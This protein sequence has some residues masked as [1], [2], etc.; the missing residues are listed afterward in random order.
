MIKKALIFYLTKFSGH[1]HA[2]VA[3]EKALRLVYGDVH[4]RNIN[5]PDYTNPIL[6]R[7][8]NKVYMEIIKKKPEIWGRMYDNIEVLKKTKKIREALHKYNMSKIKKLIKN[9]SPDAVFCTQAFPCGMISDYKRDTGSKIPLVGILTD[10]APHSYWL[11]EKVD[12]YVVPS[13]N[14]ANILREKGV[15]Q[16]KIKIYGIPVDSKFSTKHDVAAIKAKM[17][18]NPGHPTVLIMGGSQG[19]GSVEE[20]VK[21]FMGDFK[22]NYQLIV[23]TGAN[24]KLYNRLNR[25]TRKKTAGNICL[26][27]YVDN[28][29]ELMEVSDVIVTKAG[30]MTTTEALVKNL[31]MLI[32]NP[33]PG[34]EQM[35]TDYLV[36]KGAAIEI[37]KYSQIY[38]TINKLVD[39]E[40][41]LKNMKEAIKK[42]AK[43][44]SAVDIAKLVDKE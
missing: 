29:D 20:V 5:A 43:P 17:G 35:N 24:K 15:T 11:H 2:A 22:H 19:L 26:L 40:N 30:G 14:T 25:F 3:V 16:K 42:I 27:S 41:G 33:I 32:A 18:L 9:Y 1:Y 13:D 21:S 37:K 38:R 8:V 36:K 34:H 44:N 12:Y 6:G 7:I 4:V 10:H 31:P 23:V 28:I 39:S